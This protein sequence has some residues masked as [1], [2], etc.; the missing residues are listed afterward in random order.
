MMNNTPSTYPV[1]TGAIALALVGA[2]CAPVAA[3]A[4][5]NQADAAETATEVTAVAEDENTDD[6]GCMDCEI[7]SNQEYVDSL[8]GLTDAERQE[9]VA[10]Y[11]K[12]DALGED[13]DLSDAEWDRMSE[14]QNKSWYAEIEQAINDN[15]SLSDDERAAYMDRIDQL[16]ELDA[17]FE[18]YFNNPEYL[19]KCDE[20]DE[21]ISSLDDVMGWNDYDD[22]V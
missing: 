18:E 8:V 5:T 1:R 19:Q 7:M 20:Y 3:L 14:L 10:L 9:L 4:A 2:L 11:D 21:A 16:K 17:Y 15:K 12:I 22:L 6:A 13:E